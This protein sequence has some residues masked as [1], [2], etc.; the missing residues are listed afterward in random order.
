M[1][2]SGFVKMEEPKRVLAALMK[3]LD[4]PFPVTRLLKE[5]GRLSTSPVFIVGVFSGPLKLGEGYGSSIKM[6]ETRVSGPSFF[7]SL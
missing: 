4:R 1:D 6:A 3:K 2:V 5:T 7:L